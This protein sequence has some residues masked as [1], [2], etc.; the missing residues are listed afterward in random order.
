MADAVAKPVTVRDVLSV[1]KDSEIEIVN[2]IGE[3][4]IQVSM[5]FK[6]VCPLTKTLSKELLDRA[7]LATYFDIGVYVIEVAGE[8]DAE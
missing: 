7:V 8:E 2:E 5:R 3:P 6:F 4:L 1:I